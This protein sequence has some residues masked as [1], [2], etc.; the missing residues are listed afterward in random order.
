MSEFAVVVGLTAS[1]IQLVD[2][3]RKVTERIR[4]FQ[5]SRAFAHL[6]ARLPVINLTLNRIKEAQDKEL[7]D[8]KKQEVLL[9][10]VDDCRALFK[11]LDALISR[12]TPAEKDSKLRKT[13]M[14]VSSFGKDKKLK[15]I[16][17][18]LEGLIDQLANYFAVDASLA[19]RVND[20]KLVQNDASLPPPNSIADKAIFDVPAQQVSIFVGRKGLMGKIGA[21]LAKTDPDSARPSVVV[22]VGMGGQ[23]KTQLVLEYCRKHRHTYHA[24]FWVDASSAQAAAASFEKIAA[25]LEA[26]GHANL[27]PSKC[28]FVKDHLGGMQKPWMLVF[29]N[30][31]NPGAFGDI[32]SYFP[33]GNGSILC[34]SRHAETKRLGRAVPVDSLS[35]DEAVELLLR[36]S[37][38]D[39]TEVNR[40]QAKLI[41]KKLACLALAVDQ[42]AAYISL[43]HLPMTLFL[44]DYEH[45][46]RAVL[47]YV[48][49]SSLWEY[50][51]R[52]NDAEKETSLSAFTTWEM[53]IRQIAEIDAEYDAIGQFLTLSAYFNPAK[54]SESLFS[55]CSP[56]QFL[57]GSA[58]DWLKIFSPQATWNHDYF[59]D[60]VSGLTNLSLIQHY[61]STVES[62]GSSS[63]FTL[64]PL[65]SDWLQLRI[66]PEEQ[67][68]FLLQAIEVLN[69]SRSARLTFSPYV[70][71]DEVLM[72]MQV[73]FKFDEV[74]GL[75]DLDIPK[76]S[77]PA[78]RD[79][80]GSMIQS[81]F[82]DFAEAMFRKI[83]ILHENY[84]GRNSETTLRAI[85]DLGH[86]YICQKKFDRAIETLQPALLA[87]DTH[88]PNGNLLSDA[89]GH[90]AACYMEREDLKQAEE[91]LLRALETDSP[92]YW[93]IFNLSNIYQKLGDFAKAENMIIQ[94][95]EFN[96]QE[97]GEYHSA[98]L[99]AVRQLAE[100]Y[101]RA[102][103]NEEAEA[104]YLRAF[105]G[106]VR[107]RAAANLECSDLCTCLGTLYLKT[108]RFTESV[109]W[110]TEAVRL[111]MT[112]CCPD[113]PESAPFVYIAKL[114]LGHA[115]LRAGHF[116]EA[117]GYYLEVKANLEMFRDKG[118]ILTH[119][120]AYQLGRVYEGLGRLEDAAS[121][122]KEAKAVYDTIKDQDPER[123]YD[124]ACALGC[125][126][127]QLGRLE[128]AVSQ[129]KEAKAVYDTIKD[130]D[131]ERVSNLVLLLGYVYKHL[132]RLDDAVSQF[133]EAKAVC[134]GFKD[135]DPERVYDL[136]Y[137][138]GCVYARLGRL[139]D[140][141]S[142]FKEAK[143]VCDGFKDQE[144]ERVYDLA[145]QLG[146][147]YAR[148]GRLDDAVS[149]FKEA[150]AGFTKFLG[151]D[152]QHT[153]LAAE[154]FQRTTKL[155][156][157]SKAKSDVPGELHTEQQDPAKKENTP[158]PSILPNQ[159]TIQPPPS[160]LNSEHQT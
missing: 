24:V 78:L 41:V 48:P 45:R 99:A 32:K 92:S 79:L 138:L 147:V 152:H 141:V 90:L 15:E 142:Q 6:N 101:D 113:K 62:G 145:Y 114:A 132:G 66:G 64:H 118:H 89:L 19:S 86:V 73:L 131:P 128:D 154:R 38:T 47:E 93:I 36:R 139:D 34:T 70:L 133:K 83:V 129:F 122:F 104:M 135:Q 146:C 155:I 159:N 10:A 20:L 67:Q 110:S 158:K 112:N 16:Q 156:A 105:N 51:R 37:E 11:Q 96:R 126:S 115:Y 53:S 109:H 91:L 81:F 102:E 82:R 3:G 13:Y 28:E 125:I 88:F 46:K 9:G 108:D 8:T 151:I 35:E 14:S 69:A 54:I 80:A 160:D 149:Q 150:E 97:R 117:E 72:H 12:M 25:I 4:E 18:K 140:A 39:D 31:D 30:Y 100:I 74:H 130:Q 27:S 68:K 58:P 33:T 84:F 134:D 42:A 153:R 1:I 144:P 111:T 22:L 94:S 77:L 23:G 120:I 49:K 119:E 136:A 76:A 2:T 29:D 143:A 157:E 75:P 127:G 17:A 50:Q 63:W 65:I 124:L 121:Q 7:L 95:I 21:S 56:E 61:E 87:I 107:Y 85:V 40:S 44:Q 52:L 57:S 98:T 55:S 26:R 148:L 60:V 106:Y 43:R 137:Q 116:I 5:H 123:V 59:Q 103:K 71:A